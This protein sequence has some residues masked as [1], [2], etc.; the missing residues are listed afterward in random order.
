MYNQWLVTLMLESEVLLEQVAWT[1]HTCLEACCQARQ[2]LL[3]Q[4]LTPISLEGLKIESS[5]STFGIMETQETHS[6]STR[7]GDQ[8][9]VV[10]VLPSLY[11]FYMY[12]GAALALEKC[13]QNDGQNLPVHEGWDGWIDFGHFFNGQTGSSKAQVYTTH[14]SRDLHRFT[15]VATC[16]LATFFTTTKT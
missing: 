13:D 5:K 8:Q 4:L 3:L 15:L 7:C 12:C 6:V 14:V 2:I 16:L 11:S 9:R 1:S 10:N